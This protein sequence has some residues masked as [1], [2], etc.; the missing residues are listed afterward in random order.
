MENATNTLPLFV[1]SLLV[2]LSLLPFIFPAQLFS[3][4][5]IFNM[6]RSTFPASSS[7]SRSAAYCANWSLLFKIFTFRPFIGII[8][9]FYSLASIFWSFDRRAP[10]SSLWQYDSILCPPP[11][12]SPFPPPS[13][14]MLSSLP[15]DPPPLTPAKDPLHSLFTNDSGVIVS[16][17]D[18]NWAMMDCVVIDR[19][20][21]G[22]I[23]WS[24]IHGNPVYFFLP[25][26]GGGLAFFFFRFY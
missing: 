2:S 9:Y 18:C 25:F 5:S 17:T 15:K 1:S 13:T 6:L 3:F 19:S 14:T 20:A 8:L 16:R 7:L 23:G 21:V 12:P 10:H 11:Q 4:R 26:L 24:V 22:G